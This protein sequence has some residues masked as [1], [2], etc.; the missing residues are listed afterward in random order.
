MNKLN[1]RCR[2]KLI[3]YCLFIYLFINQT[4]F[5]ATYTMTSGQLYIV[6]DCSNL[7]KISLFGLI[8]R[9][10]IAIAVAKIYPCNQI[11]RSDLSELNTFIYIQFSLPTHHNMTSTFFKSFNRYN[12]SGRN[13]PTDWKVHHKYY[14]FKPYLKY[15]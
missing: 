11:D 12:Y 1:R 2:V 8:K 14:I 15:Y 7:N 5:S 3:S 13:F 10:D 4:L 9:T 6:Y